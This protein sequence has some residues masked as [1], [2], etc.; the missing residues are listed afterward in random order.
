[1]ADTRR[2]LSYLGECYVQLKL[3]KK[4]FRVIKLSGFPF[5]FLGE[6]GAKLEVKA[7]LPAWGRKYVARVNKTYRWKKWQFR[8]S[9]QNQRASDFFICICFETIERPPVGVLC[10]TERSCCNLGKE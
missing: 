3:A 10:A 5:D 7:A 2:K 9:T 6:N 4:G 1:M 8:I